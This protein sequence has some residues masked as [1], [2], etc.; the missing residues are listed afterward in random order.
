MAI[1]NY[2]IL[3]C[4]YFR[5]RQDRRIIMFFG[6]II[7]LKVMSY[8]VLRINYVILMLDVQDPL[9]YQHRLIMRIS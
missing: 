7:T 6:M 8:N 2:P 1:I 9:V 5:A 3:N 4:F